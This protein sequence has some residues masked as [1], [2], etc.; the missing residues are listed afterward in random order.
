MPRFG[1]ETLADETVVPRLANHHTP[2]VGDAKSFSDPSNR[3]LRFIV[4][5][6]LG[7][8]FLHSWDFMRAKVGGRRFIFEVPAKDAPGRPPPEDEGG[9]SAVRRQTAAATPLHAR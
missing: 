7:K 1:D 2:F 3:Y 8:A 6:Y 5:G 9:G 4:L